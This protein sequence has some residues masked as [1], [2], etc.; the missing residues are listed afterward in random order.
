[1]AY[2]IHNFSASTSH[3]KLV[4]IRNISLGKEQ[5]CTLTAEIR[6]VIAVEK[7]IAA[8]VSTQVEHNREAQHNMIFLRLLWRLLVSSMDQIA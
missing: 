6:E 1:M 8:V 7:L 3:T 2:Q 5:G 4:G